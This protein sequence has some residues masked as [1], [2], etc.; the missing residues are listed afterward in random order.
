MIR[1]VYL[2]QDRN[3]WPAIVNTVM[4]NKMQGL[5]LPVEGLLTL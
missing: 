4:N 5:S 1:W 2:D 3:Q